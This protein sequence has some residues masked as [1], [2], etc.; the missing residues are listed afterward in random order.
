ML[1]VFPLVAG[2]AV[3]ARPIITA[4]YREQYLPSVPIM[5]LLA[6]CLIPAFLD[7]PVGALL[8]A[9]RRQNTQTALM[10]VTM[11]IGVALNLILIPRFGG[12]GS[13]TAALVGNS[14]LFIGGLIAIVKLVDIP[15]KKLLASFLRIAIAS[16]A[17]AAVV[18]FVDRQLSLYY[19]IA[20]GVLVYIGALFVTREI[21]RNDVVRLRD[22]IKTPSP[23]TIETV[24]DI[25]V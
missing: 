24:T 8:N 3:M 16:V 21:G 7:F 14:V 23:E 15:W 10:G 1:I 4:F 22:L 18:V 19:S 9:A 6:W 12:M 20:I 13:A 17:M 25:N 5:M 2:M 11:V